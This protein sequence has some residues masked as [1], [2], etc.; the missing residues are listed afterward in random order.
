MNLYKKNNK[1]TASF[2]CICCLYLI[3]TMQ[4]LGI[5][6][7]LYLLKLSADNGFWKP[8][9]VASNQGRTPR[10]TAV[11]VADVKVFSKAD[12]KDGFLWDTD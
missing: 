10:T 7:I 8:L 11:H 2:P 1:Y 5:T 3:V 9:S 12:L 4:L 6:F